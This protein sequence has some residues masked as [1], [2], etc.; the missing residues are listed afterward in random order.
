MRALLACLLLGLGLPAQTSAALDALDA[1]EVARALDL[2]E[3][4]SVP[5][6]PDLRLQVIRRLVEVPRTDAALYER[7]LGR[8]ALLLPDGAAAGHGERLQELAAEVGRNLTRALAAHTDLV[9]DGRLTDRTH[10]GAGLAAERALR[11][12]GLADSRDMLAL[13]LHLAPLLLVG[14]RPRDAANLATDALTATATP[15]QQAALH[16]VLARALLQLGRPEEA[17][18]HIKHVVLT[19]PGDAQ[20]V[21][22]LVKALP[23][24]LDTDTFAMLRT[25]IRVAPSA[26]AAADWTDSVAA[27]Y[28]IA[29]R[30]AAK[31]ASIVADLTVRMPLPQTWFQVQWGEGYRIWMDANSRPAKVASGKDALILPVPQSAGWRRRT[32]PPEELTRWNNAAYCLQRGED[33]PTLVVYWF[34]PNLEYWYGDTPTERGVTAKTVRGHSAG[35]I[36]RMVFDIAYGEDAK[37]RQ[38]KFKSHAAPPFAVAERGQRRTFAIGDTIYD[39]TVFSHGQVTIEVLL[40]VTE[41]DLAALEPELRWMYQNLHKD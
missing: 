34:G 3:A 9:V 4:G 40:R 12:G 32:R 38:L 25:L 13:G 2:L 5:T 11:L 10:L 22:P 29:D 1:G 17:L 37:R 24:S 18:P 33:G 8:A 20:V 36:A 31:R 7:A 27:F 23:P 19:A 21:W 15:A 39:E 6:D 28:A 26:G 14:E 41:K 16:D 35:A 30:L